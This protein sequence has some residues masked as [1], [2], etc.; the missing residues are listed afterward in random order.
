MFLTVLFF[1]ERTGV[2][3]Q[4]LRPNIHMSVGIRWV[5]LLP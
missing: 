3:S 2:V 1:A 5:R 4:S